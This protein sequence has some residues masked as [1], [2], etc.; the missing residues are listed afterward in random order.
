MKK[1]ILPFLVILFFISCDNTH[2]EYP[3]NEPTTKDL[4]GKMSIEEIMDIKW[5]Q[6]TTLPFKNVE[7]NLKYLNQDEAFKFVKRLFAK[8]DFIIEF[9]YFDNITKDWKSK[10]LN[11]NNWEIID[12]FRRN[13]NDGFIDYHFAVMPLNELLGIQILKT[14]L[15]MHSSLAD[16]IYYLYFAGDSH[17][18]LRLNNRKIVRLEVFD[19]IFPSGFHQFDD[20]TKSVMIKVLEK[21][22]LTK[23]EQHSFIKYTSNKD[24]MFRYD[25]NNEMKINSIIGVPNYE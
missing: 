5:S 7:G 20:L 3:A 19:V 18:L 2:H 8:N 14:N 21:K 13:R 9:M 6:F 16:G 11:I 17:P 24:A 22:Q 25:Q 12:G 10:S 1:I 15:D 23:D 4:M